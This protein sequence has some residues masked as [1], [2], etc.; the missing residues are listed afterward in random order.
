MQLVGGPIRLG[1]DVIRE[2]IGE[3][4]YHFVMRFARK[5]KM[6]PIT[7]RKL[8]AVGSLCGLNASEIEEASTGSNETT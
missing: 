2:K 5:S 8:N 7:F 4:A 3:N 1:L 6:D